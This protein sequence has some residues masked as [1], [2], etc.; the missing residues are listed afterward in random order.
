MGEWTL[1]PALERKVGL[2]FRGLEFRVQ[3]LGP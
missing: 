2:A 1:F 3:G